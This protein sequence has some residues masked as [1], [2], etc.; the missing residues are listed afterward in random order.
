MI[1]GET[2]A[3]PVPAVLSIDHRPQSERLLPSGAGVGLGSAAPVRL[4]ELRTYDLHPM[5]TIAT[6]PW[7]YCF[8]ESAPSN[9]RRAMTAVLCNRSLAWRFSGS[10]DDR[11]WPG[12]DVRE[13]QLF[14]MSMRTAGFRQGNRKLEYPQSTPSG[15][16]RLRF[17]RPKADVD[18]DTGIQRRAQPARCNSGLG[19]GVP[20]GAR[21]AVLTFGAVHSAHDSGRSRDHLQQGFRG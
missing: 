18:L 6:R 2:E 10:S 1:L 11:K 15:S 3:A 12:P 13:R 8:G 4:L 5:P 14:G 16:P 17:R 7:G 9:G 21:R 20:R 19:G